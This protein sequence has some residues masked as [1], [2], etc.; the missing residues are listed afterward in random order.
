MLVDD[1]VRPVCAQW[2]KSAS[3]STIKTVNEELEYCLLNPRTGAS[4]ASVMVIEA[5]FVASRLP[6]VAI[7]SSELAGTVPG[8]VDPIATPANASRMTVRREW[9]R[10]MVC[11]IKERRNSTIHD[12]LAT[13]PTRGEEEEKKD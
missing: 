6:N 11:R 4:F 12:E 5:P 3:R 7:K 8:G 9:T 2:R 1:V 13:H 10:S